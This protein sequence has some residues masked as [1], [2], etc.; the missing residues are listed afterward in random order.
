VEAYPCSIPLERWLGMIKQRF[1]STFS[2]FSDEELELACK[3]IAET[4]THRLDKQGR[5]HFEDRLVFLSAR[6]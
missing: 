2:S 6:A 1:W 3:L 4:E 5:I